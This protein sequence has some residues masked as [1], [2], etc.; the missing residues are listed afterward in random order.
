MTTTC[1]EEF[2]TVELIVNSKATTRGVDAFA[3][4]LIKAERQ[5]RRLVT[6]LIYQFPCFSGS[7]VA[8]LRQTLA[9]NRQVYLEG[10]EKGF[11][12]LYPLSVAGLV[13]KAYPRLRQRMQEAT[14]RRRK[15][16][17]GQLT[18][19][20]LTR[21][22]LLDF[23]QD[24]RDWCDALACGAQKEFDYDG[25]V[26][27]SFRKSRINGLHNRFKIQIVSIQD[28]EQFVHHYL[29]R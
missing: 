18:A 4:S 10:F 8:A 24:I 22:D 19:K 20:N 26:R 28:Y 15:I 13:G 29:E 12:A 9:N 27:N 21:R 3:L 2:Q 1:A 16:F 23:V 7:D 11:D 14:D 5:M 17:H 6:H 25:F